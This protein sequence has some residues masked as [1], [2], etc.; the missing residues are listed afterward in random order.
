MFKKHGKK[1][2]FGLVIIVIVLLA[3]YF[4]SPV[5]KQYTESIQG[6]YYNNDIIDHVTIN[7]DGEIQKDSKLW[8]ADMTF[9]G[10]ISVEFEENKDL[11]FSF[12]KDEIYFYNWG[13][14]RYT[15]DI[16]P[17]EEVEDCVHLC[18]L[19]EEW[20]Q[21][22]IC[23]ILNEDWE[24]YDNSESAYEE[25]EGAL[26]LE[27]GHTIEGGTICAPATNSEEFNQCSNKALG[28]D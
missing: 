10:E 28:Q 19:K 26:S 17:F 7:F 3:I 24:N 25:V 11:N 18:Y 15:Y 22:Y 27:N 12:A 21:L 20:N 14:G 13:I 5:R 16:P 1:M 9:A 8:N 23:M 4:L 6:I 2:I